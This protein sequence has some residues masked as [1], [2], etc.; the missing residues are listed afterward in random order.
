MQGGHGFPRW[1]GWLL[2]ASTRRT[3]ELGE[4]GIYPFGLV[5]EVI[6]QEEFCGTRYM[7]TRILDSEL[8]FVEMANEC[9]DP[10][11]AVVGQQR[12]VG[13]AGNAV[14]MMLQGVVKTAG[15]W[16]NACSGRCLCFMAGS[17]DRCTGR[18]SGL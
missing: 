11:S 5:I 17:C 7:P 6:Q 18:S 16:G 8:Q 12:G 4:N 13:G 10:V 3:N 9:V 14:E 15:W 1:W 2:S